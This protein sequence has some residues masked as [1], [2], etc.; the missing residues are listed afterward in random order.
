MVSL[1]KD[2][3]IRLVIW[4]AL[5][6]AVYALYGYRHSKMRHRPAS[7]A[8]AASQGAGHAD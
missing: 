5:G 3:W 1:P 6:L 8:L 2:T 7:A 4:I